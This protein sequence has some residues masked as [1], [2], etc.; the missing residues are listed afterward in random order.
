MCRVGGMCKYTPHAS[1]RAIA[2]GILVLPNVNIHGT[3]GR[4]WSSST[5]N[6]TRSLHEHGL[7]VSNAIPLHLKGWKGIL[8]ADAC[9]FRRIRPVVPTTSGQPFRGIRPPED[10]CREGIFVDVRLFGPRQRSRR[11]CPIFAPNDC[12]IPGGGRYGSAGRGSIG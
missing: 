5:A 8:Q 4:F 2:F 6:F 7:I 10:R 11:D 3:M 9:A 12:P 1:P